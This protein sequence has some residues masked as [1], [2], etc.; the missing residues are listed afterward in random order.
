MQF[1]ITTTYTLEEYERFN[2]AISEVI[3]GVNK[4]AI[5]AVIIYFAIVLVFVLRKEYTTAMIVV[6]LIVVM[7]LLI[8]RSVDKS[9]AKAYNTNIILKDAV[10]KYR[11]MEDR[12]EADSPKGKEIV[13]YKNIYCLLENDTNFYIMI[14]DNM[15]FII[16]KKNCTKEQ[17]DF[18]RTIAKPFDPK[19]K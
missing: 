3:H 6:I 7:V 8:R 13:E 10:V 4:K 14:G 9:V 18:I 5:V 15:G 16:S 19:K 2:Q 17:Q 12:L 11:F 1:E